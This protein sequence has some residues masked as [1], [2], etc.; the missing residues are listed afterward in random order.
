VAT[1]TTFWV[2]G[3]GFSIGCNLQV[4]GN[5]IN[6]TG[7]GTNPSQEGSVVIPNTNDSAQYQMHDIVLPAQ[8][9]N[10]LSDFWAQYLQAV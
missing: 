2:E 5:D 7:T 1:L 9:S 10:Q 8:G 4:E 3:H 6:Q